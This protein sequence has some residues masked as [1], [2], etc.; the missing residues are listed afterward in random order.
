MPAQQV[1]VQAQHAVASHRHEQQNKSQS[2]GAKYGPRPGSATFSS[3][4][5]GQSALK[6]G[7][8]NPLA[9]DSACAPESPFASVA[10]QP[11]ASDPAPDHQ[12]QQDK[13]EGFGPRPQ[14]ASFS[15]AVPQAV[16]DSLACLQA[17]TDAADSRMLQLQHDPAKTVAQ[18]VPHANTLL[19]SV[20]ALSNSTGPD[21]VMLAP[22]PLSSSPGD[23]E[24]CVRPASAF[25]PVAEA[26]PPA[27]WQAGA[28]G[29]PCREEQPFPMQPD[30]A[31]AQVRTHPGTLLWTAGLYQ[32]LYVNPKH[33]EQCLEDRLAV[34]M[35]CI[36][37]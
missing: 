20:P 6:E 10:D 29:E 3:T 2:Q 9:K 8:L 18:P 17:A 13:S 37:E 19:A 23:A 14:S 16:S 4:V 11:H 28:Q 1:P 12:Q 33:V 32:L 7:Q 35:I 5:P 24:L 15:S 36:V 21:S 31:Q 25:A 26:A 34:Y 22:G 30:D 27:E